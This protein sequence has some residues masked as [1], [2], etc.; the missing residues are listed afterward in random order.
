MKISA[1]SAS[2]LRTWLQCKYKYG[3]IYHKFQAKPVKENEDYLTMGLADHAALEYAGSLVKT[4]SL[5]S[6]DEDDIDKIVR[7]YMS[8]CSRLN[9]GDE[10]VIF[11]GLNLLLSKLDKF[12]FNQKI[13]T[14]E[15]NFK[16]EVAGVP[17]IGA[18]DKVVEFN[19]STLC[20]IDYK[21]SHS[22][23]T[24]NEIDV[25]IQ[26]SLYD[27]AARVLFPDY[28]KYIVCLDYLR[29]FP[30]YSER[31]EEQRYSFIQLLKTNYELILKAKKK[32]LKPELNKFCPW[33]EYINVCPAIKEIKDNIPDHHIFDDENAL[34]DAYDKMRI[35]VK[36]LELKMKEIK[37][38]L[39]KKIN[40]SN[41]NKIVTDEF[42]IF[43][44]QI[45]RISY[46]PYA[47]Y[48]I[49][50]ADDLVKCVSVVNKKLNDLIKKKI[51]TKEEADAISNVSYTTSI[52]DI[53]R[54]KK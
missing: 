3:C 21:T 29:F 44:R 18:M 51:I 36:S 4:K 7:V 32:D 31:T 15:K 14:L 33:C 5:K 47:L 9:I 49:V 48:S 1:L 20:V 26:L 35:L 50:G 53:R 41:N 54:K 17:V 11:D 10:A 16:V 45:P 28:S 6:F 30:K 12:E 39:V 42:N 2:R 22:V 25:D 40:A 19:N 13:I 46:D 24:D 37:S 23:L 34:A 38:I 52:L 8:E 27:S 43:T